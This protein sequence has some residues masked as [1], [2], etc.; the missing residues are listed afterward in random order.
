MRRDGLN[1]AAVRPGWLGLPVALRVYIKNRTD[2]RCLVNNAQTVSWFRVSLI[3]VKGYVCA[4]NTCLPVPWRLWSCSRLGLL[5]QQGR[6]L[7]T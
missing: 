7:Q 3:H 6:L 5:N 1:V 4:A 2:N